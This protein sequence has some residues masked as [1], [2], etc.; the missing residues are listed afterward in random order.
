MRVRPTV[1]VLLIDPEQRLLLFASAASREPTRTVWFAAGGGIEPGENAADAARREVREETGLADVV[2]GPHVWSRR[3]VL[4]SGDDVVDLREVFFLAHVPAFEID[5]TGF[6]PA[7]RDFV[8]AWRWWT[9]DEL[10]ATTDLLAPRALPRLLHEL[11]LHGP[12]PSPI[13]LGT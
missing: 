9:V 4:R 7:E 6:T 1:R 10:D 13:S 12:P 3:H 2:L 11:L 8:T 5:T